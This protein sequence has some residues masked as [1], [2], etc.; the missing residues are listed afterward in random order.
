MAHPT[1]AALPEDEYL[2]LVGQFAYMVAGIEGLL[3]FDMPQHAA[4]LPPALT[5]EKMAAQTTT[6]MG[7]LLLAHAPTIGDS[8][9]R[10]YYVEGG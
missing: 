7:K 10:A 8:D 3:I 1:R 6:G 9:I 2:I 4:V 5:V